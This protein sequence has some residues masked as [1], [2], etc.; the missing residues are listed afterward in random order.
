M[1]EEPIKTFYCVMCRT[2]LTE[3]KG[4]LVCSNQMCGRWGLITLAASTEPIPEQQEIV[5]KKIGIFTVIDGGK[6]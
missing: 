3:H 2:P 4:T 5:G 1:S 6:T